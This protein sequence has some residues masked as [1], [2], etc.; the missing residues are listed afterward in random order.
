MNVQHI[1]M[2][3]FTFKTHDTYSIKVSSILQKIQLI[4]NRY[5]RYRQ[6]LAYIFSQVSTIS[7]C[8]KRPLTC[9]I[10]MQL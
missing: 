2:H 3:A 7:F 5:K 10:L 9:H 6:H 4:P 1:N 8:S